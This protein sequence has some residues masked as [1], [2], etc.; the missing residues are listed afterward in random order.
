MGTAF[1]SGIS[2]LI[3]GVRFWKAPSE[4]GTHVGNIWSSTGTVLASVTFTNET[5]SG[6]QQQRLN[7]P[8]AIAANTTY[9]V[10]VNI[11]N[12]YYVATVGGLSSQ[13]VNGDLKTVVGNNGVYGTPGQFP[14]T[15]SNGANYFRDIFFTPNTL[16][17]ISGSISP[18]TSGNGAIVS[19]SGAASATVGVNSSGNYTFA[20]VINGSYT[21]TPTNEGFT[22]SPTSAPVTVNNANVTGVNF[23]GATGIPT[24]TLFT[25]QTPGLTN[26]TDGPTTNYEMGTAFTS[27]VAG[28]ITGV[29]FWKANSEAGTHTGNIW[30]A[31][32]QLLASSDFRQ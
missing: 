18:S 13:A 5:S 12:G 2:G 8:L 30:S 4:S 28:Y 11:A 17:S 6:W 21:V 20:G 3:T 10:S 14:N 9:V 22:F 16:Y 1:T 7:T 25:T 31:A 32:G 26:Q 29:R 23:T 24:Q 19:L 15:S 27:D